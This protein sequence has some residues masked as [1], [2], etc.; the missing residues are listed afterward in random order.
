MPSSTIEQ[1][2]VDLLNI[3]RYDSL[4][5][6]INTYRAH[7]RLIAQIHAYVFDESEIPHA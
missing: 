3:E 7:S 5:D 4:R 1:Y 2:F 6:Y